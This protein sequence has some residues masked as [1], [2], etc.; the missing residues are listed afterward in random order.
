MFPWF[1]AEG[2]HVTPH[3]TTRG[4]QRNPFLSFF[5]S[6][7]SLVEIVFFLFMT[8]IL[9]IFPCLHPIIF[10]GIF[11]HKMIQVS[12]QKVTVWILKSHF[13][14]HINICHTVWKNINS[15]SWHG[16]HKNRQTW[17]VILSIHG[18]WV[19]M[20]PVFLK[21]KGNISPPAIFS[22]I[23]LVS[24]KL[25]VIQR[26]SGKEQW[27]LDWGQKFDFLQRRSG[28][29][30]WGWGC[31]AGG[32]E[33]DRGAVVGMRKKDGGVPTAGQRGG[34]CWCGGGGGTPSAFCGDGQTRRTKED[35][36]EE[37]AGEWGGWR[38]FTVAP[39]TGSSRNRM[40]SF[41][42]FLFYFFSAGLLILQ[43]LV[44]H[45]FFCSI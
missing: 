31:S 23:S 39:P 33:C 32:G 5:F 12:I 45:L 24:Q 2:L 16:M 40:S 22:K 15:G 26:S 17:S 4:Q 11:L 30:V 13:L 43:F 10:F 42:S 28:P 37:D 36:R 27:K 41:L 9:R 29:D 1:S 18:W 7:F 8:L 35:M 20:F 14:S 21:V 34:V 19:C 3:M 25:W 6:F 38:C 44:L